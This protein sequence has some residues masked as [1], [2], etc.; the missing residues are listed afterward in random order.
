MTI[1]ELETLYARLDAMRM[2]PAE[3]ALA[4]ARLEQAEAFAAAMHHAATA[5]RKLL[6]RRPRPAATSGFVG[7]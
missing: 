2:T 7:S 3:R 6:S 5:V 1:T 4:R